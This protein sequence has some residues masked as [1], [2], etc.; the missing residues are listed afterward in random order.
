MAFVRGNGPALRVRGRKRIVHTPL[1]RREMFLVAIFILIMAIVCIL[2][3]YVGWWTL[4]KEE[5]EWDHKD[6]NN[7]PS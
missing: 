3:M 7:H 1:T 2:A 5:Q 4:Q 6:A